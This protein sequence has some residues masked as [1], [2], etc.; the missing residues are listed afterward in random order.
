[1]KKSSTVL[2]LLFFV[3][4]LGAFNVHSL[5]AQT[6]TLNGIVIDK[7]TQNLL[8]D[9]NIKILGTGFSARTIG[10]GSFRITG[11]PAGTY[12]V[13]FTS[14]NYQRYIEND[15]VISTGIERE[16]LVE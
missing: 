16:L 8:K 13:E 15:V 2:L 3:I 9:I 4:T 11:I 6:G 7:A 12:E 1:M 14:V 10:D 5:R